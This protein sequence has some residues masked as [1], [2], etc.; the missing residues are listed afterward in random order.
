MLV[1]RKYYCNNTIHRTLLPAAG[2]P[3]NATLSCGFLHKQGNACIQKNICFRYYG[4]LYV[5]S[6][7][8]VYVD[9]ITGEEYPIGPGWVLQ[10]MPGISHHTIIDKDSD[11][12]EFYFCASADIFEALANMNMVTRKPVFYVGEKEEIFT[13][14][15]TYHEK[16]CTTND[17]RAG[18]LLIEF[19]KLLCFMNEQIIY[20]PHPNVADKISSVLNHNY[21]VGVPLKEIAEECGISY[22]KLRKDFPKYFG[23]SMEKYCI[24][25]RINAAKK[26][27]LDQQLPIKTVAAELGYCDVYAFSNQFK[28]QEGI[29]PGRFIVNWNSKKAR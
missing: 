27:L 9:S 2:N 8:G 22:E 17:I 11:W 10:R 29:S 23:C 5:I 15:L 3:A 20:T 21:K 18:E 19:Q 24:R 26:M 12:L 14:L 25:L 13:R 28:Q 7:T 16:F 4:G 6:G 1:E